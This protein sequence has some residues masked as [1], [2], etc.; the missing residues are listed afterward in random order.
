M[1]A[2]HPD[3]HDAVG[4]CSEDPSSRVLLILKPECARSRSWPSAAADSG[5]QQQAGRRY[6]PLLRHEVKG[7]R[8]LGS[9]GC[10][11]GRENSKAS[12]QNVTK[13]TGLCGLHFKSRAL[14]NYLRRRSPGPLRGSI[15]P[16]RPPVPARPPSGRGTGGYKAKSKARNPDLS[17]IPQ[18]QFSP[19]CSCRPLYL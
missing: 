11:T 6:D 18:S 1:K 14:L 9:L 13:E 16:L 17:Q 19:R 3:H 12:L 15:L 5:E 2:E 8:R 7:V 4:R 10:H